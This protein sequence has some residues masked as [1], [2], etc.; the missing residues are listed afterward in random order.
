[1]YSTHAFS[2]FSLIYLFFTV[3]DGGKI[4][5]CIQVSLTIYC[6]SRRRRIKLVVSLCKWV[7]SRF[8]AFY[9]SDGY[10]WK[11]PDESHTDD[12]GTTMGPESRQPVANCSPHTYPPLLPETKYTPL[13]PSHQFGIL[14]HLLWC[15]YF[16]SF[17]Q[18]SIPNNLLS[19]FKVIFNRCIEQYI[20]TF[21]T[22]P[23]W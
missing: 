20:G 15:F 21:I 23:R 9:T 3:N 11:L 17:D 14:S 1:M 10:Y 5:G 2:I 8:F 22:E 7:I 18:F 4:M 13:Q 16:L 6:N 19:I 12:D